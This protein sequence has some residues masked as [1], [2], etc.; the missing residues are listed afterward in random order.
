[1]RKRIR[2]SGGIGGWEEERGKFCEEKGWSAAKVERRWVEGE[3]RGEVLVW[4]ERRRQ[5]AER[6]RKVVEA[7]RNKEYKFVKGREVPGYLK[8]G[9]EEGSWQ[10]MARFR[11][12]EE[13]RGTLYWEV[14]EKRLCRECGVEEE[15]WEHVWEKCTGWGREKGWQE[16]REMVLGDD[17][18]GEEWL[19]R[20]E[21]WRANQV[22]G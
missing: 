10:R 6:W 1:M 17:G 18:R 8:K 5:D 11:L 7:K 16:M 15:T 9:W 2:S 22:E 14:E 12:G 13:M 20:I 21:K 4:V 19:E 3:M